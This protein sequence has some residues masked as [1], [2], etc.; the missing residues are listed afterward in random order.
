MK[1]R[2]ASALAVVALFVTPAVANAATIA[3]APVKPCYGVGETLG[4]GGT[5]YTPNGSVQVN[6]NGQ[7]LG[8]VG[9]DAT[10]NFVGQLT[11]GKPRG[12]RT[13]T[14]IDTTTPS[15]TATQASLHLRV[16]SVV[17]SVKPKAGRPGRVV[18]IK[19][20]GF[21]TGKMLYVHIVRG[22]TR[23]NRRVGKLK[24]ACHKLSVRKKMFSRHTKTGKYT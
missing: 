20:R 11:L 1:I 15:S 5:G 8:A 23:L 9:S 2:S 4:L 6:S 13:Y 19:A 24:G 16:S 21:T 10:G 14:A 18:R 7:S 12:L 3:V 22:H 17:V